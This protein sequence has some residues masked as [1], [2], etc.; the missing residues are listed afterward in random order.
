[1]TTLLT[2]FNTHEGLSA[3]TSALGH[4]KQGAA[5]T[6]GIDSGVSVT[7]SD[8]SAGPASYNQTW[9]IEVETLANE[10]KTDLNTIKTDLNLI[11]T[12]LSALLT[13]L[14]TAGIITT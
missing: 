2:D 3:T 8:V 5:V 12:Q 1:I 11:N 14:E 13:S 6:D 7:S 10:L 9:G 4:V